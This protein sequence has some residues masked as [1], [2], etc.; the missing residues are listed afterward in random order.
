MGEIFGLCRC[1]AMFRVVFRFSASMLVP[2]ILSGCKAPTVCVSL[3][4]YAVTA[5]IR[6]STSGAPA[7]FGAR[8]SI[9]DGSFVDSTLI[10]NGDSTKALHVSLGGARPGTYTL[11]VEKNGYRTWSRAGLVASETECGV[12]NHYQLVRLVRGTA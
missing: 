10:L 7:A 12:S 9:R 1:V 11:R 8:V 5:E 6:D 2:V 4:Q 3:P